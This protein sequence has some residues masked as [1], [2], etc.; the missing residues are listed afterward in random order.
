MYKIGQTEIENAISSYVILYSKIHGDNKNA[1][2]LP[3]EYYP[4]DYIRNM[5]KEKKN[6][7]TSLILLKK[8]RLSR[9]SYFI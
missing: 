5:T 1:N 8:Q 4:G 3:S 2:I 7:K 9:S 6:K